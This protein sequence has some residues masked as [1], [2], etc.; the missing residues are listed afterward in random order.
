MHRCS[1]L[2]LLSGLLGAVMLYL[3]SWSDAAHIPPDK[4]VITLMPKFGPVRFSHLRHS[5][6]LDVACQDCH[7]TI[8]DTDTGQIQGCHACHQ[9]ADSRVAAIRPIDKQQQASRND[10]RPASARQV[11]HG[12]CMGCHAR[13]AGQGM[14]SGPSDS[15]RD[16]HE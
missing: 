12:L 13:R 8:T 9:A 4:A 11:L 16:C 1:L 2:V 5:S 15:C 6:A 10:P 7:H 14:P 3:P